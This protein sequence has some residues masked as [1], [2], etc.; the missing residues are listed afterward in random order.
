MRFDD[1][2]IGHLG[3][4]AR[5]AFRFCKNKCDA[6]DLAQETLCRIYAN[7][8]KFDN[9]RDFKPWALTVMT[10]L[11]KTQRARKECV[12]FMALADDLDT[13]ASSMADN[14]AN[15]NDILEAVRRSSRVAVG[16]QCV[17]LY[18]E[19]Y[20]YDEI[21]GMLGIRTGTVK[22]RIAAG[23]AAIRNALDGYSD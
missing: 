20:S 11:F 1:V 14:L 4:I 10:N 12:P 2:V 13:P 8:M 16:V 6:D 9:A 18:A 3:W 15:Y 7:R 19:G 17:L 23:R 21:S 22:S 5:I